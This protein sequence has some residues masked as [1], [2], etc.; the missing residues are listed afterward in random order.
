MEPEEPAWR[1]VAAD[2]V[3]LEDGTGIV[4]IAPAFGEDDMRVGVENGLPVIQLVNAE[5]RFD[6]RVPQWAGM[7]VKEADPLIMKDLESRGLIFKVAQCEH[8]YPFCWRCDTPLLC[9]ARA[10]WFIKMSSLREQL[11]ANNSEIS[12][13][14]ST[15]ATAG[16]ATSLIT[17]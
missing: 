5:G 12:W 14:L 3:S 13:Y 11:L 8:T 4:H 7:F 6:E 16:S 1:V 10:S 17:L 9:Y 2:F 15:S